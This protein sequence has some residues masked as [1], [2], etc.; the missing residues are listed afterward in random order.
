MSEQNTRTIV[1]QL[2]VF[3]SRRISSTTYIVALLLFFMPFI[4]IKCNDKSLLKITGKDLVTGFNAKKALKNPFGDLPGYNRSERSEGSEK[5][6]P[7]ESSGADDAFGNDKQLKKITNPNPFAITAAILCLVGIVFSFLKKKLAGI[8]AAT[9]GGISLVMMAIIFFNL[10]PQ[11]SEVD[12]GSGL[13]FSMSISIAFSFWFYL[14][15]V[16]LAVG[17]YFSFQSYREIAGQEEAERMEEYARQFNYDPVNLDEF[18]K[19]E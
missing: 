19:E 12:A 18:A 8:I 10:Y 6:N 14:C 5:D 4:N 17:A 15:V 7:F 1:L 16:L 2:P 13:G 3:K 11:M 9:A